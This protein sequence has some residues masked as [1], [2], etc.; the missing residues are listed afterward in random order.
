MSTKILVTVPDV[1]TPTARSVYVINPVTGKFEPLTKGMLY[2]VDLYECKPNI[3]GDYL[4]KKYKLIKRKKFENFFM[5][6]DKTKEMS[7]KQKKEKKKNRFVTWSQSEIGADLFFKDMVKKNQPVVDFMHFDPNVFE[8]MKLVTEH[9]LHP[10]PIED[11]ES[12]VENG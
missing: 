10:E 3:R 9:V 11:I 7:D 8:T 6:Y 5:A 1:Q 4:P 2:I 12:E